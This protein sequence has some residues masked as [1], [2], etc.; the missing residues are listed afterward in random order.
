MPRYTSQ[1]IVYR[2]AIG[3]NAKGDL[4]AIKQSAPDTEAILIALLQEIAS[5]QW[6]LESL[7][8]KDFGY[9]RNEK[10]HVDKWAKQQGR[11]RDRNLWRFKSWDLE[12]QGMQYRV[13][14]CL[15]PRTR[16]Y[17]VLAVL[18]RDF[19][20]DESKPRVKQLLAD[21][22]SLGIPSYC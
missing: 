22:D 11:G 8:I 1:G 3:E 10:I 19:D 7:T 16:A 21:Y 6:L 15:D 12:K 2:L 9:A 14:Y 17:L 4:A 20:Y 5:S 13:V 18:H